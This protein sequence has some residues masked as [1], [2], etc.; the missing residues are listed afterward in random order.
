M[1][2][3]VADPALVAHG[4]VAVVAAEQE[5]SALGDDA[6]LAVQPGI[7][8]G[9]GPAVADGLDLRDGVRHLEQ[10]AAAVKQLAL[11]IRAQA[12]AQH[13]DVLYVHDVA[14]LIDLRRC[15]ELALVDD[16]DVRLF[17]AAV[18]LVNVA[19]RR[20]DLGRGLQTDTAAQND[21][22]V[23][24]VGRGLD[25]PD[26][27]AVFLVVILGNERLRRLG[28]AHRAVFKVELCHWLSP[29]CFE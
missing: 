5:L 15:Q 22:A 28:R 1:L 27:H 16:D 29:I 10:P 17:A 4:K 23:A 8:R 2:A 7:D 14:E 19:V 9:L 20:N 25:Q 11:E 24:L 13:W 3:D 26:V 6:A 21:R 18:E 12:E